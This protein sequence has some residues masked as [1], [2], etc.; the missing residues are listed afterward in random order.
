MSERATSLPCPGT[1]RATLRLTAPP[2]GAQ[3]YSPSGRRRWTLLAGTFW[4][5]ERHPAA[6]RGDGA[7]FP[8]IT[9]MP[10]YDARAG[11]ASASIRR[12][13]GMLPSLFAAVG[14]TRIAVADINGDLLWSDELPPGSLATSPVFPMDFD[15][16]GVTD[17]LLRTTDGVIA[18]RGVV[19]AGAVVYS[20]LTGALAL[21][22][23][24]VWVLQNPAALSA[25]WFRRGAARGSGR[26]A[27]RYR[28]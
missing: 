14:E 11:R 28:R 17:L 23:V 12:Q 22:M 5:A 8:S 3:S 4:N 16:D 7:L 19:N 1:V 20:V 9:P 6:G 25:A 21:S 26:G 24:L 18:Y 2:P 15:G 10:L 13:N 27:K